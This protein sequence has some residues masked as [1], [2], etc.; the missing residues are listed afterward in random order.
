[1]PIETGE[2]LIEILIALA[3]ISLT[4]VALL[5]GLVT[6]ITSSAEHRS[7]ATVDA[8]LKS[9]AET[10]KYQI[11]E[12][13]NPLF[14]CGATVNPAPNGYLMLSTPNPSSGPVGTAVTIFGTGFTANSSAFAVTFPTAG[15]ISATNVSGSSTSHGNAT[16]SFT[17]PPTLATGSYPITVTSGSGANAISTTTPTAFQVMAGTASGSTSPLAGFTLGISSILNWDTSASPA[18]FDTKPGCLSDYGLQMLTLSATAPNNVGDT[19]SFVVSGAPSAQAPTITS[20]PTTTFTVGSAGAFTFTATGYPASVFSETGALPSGVSLD[21]AGLLYGTPA[22]FS[23]GDYPITVTASNG[24]SPNATQSFTLVVGQAP[25]IT[26]APNTAFTMGTAGSFAVAATGFPAPTF[27]ETGALPSGVS[28]SASGV[29]SGTPAPGTLGTYGT[30]NPP[31]T[32]TA[33]NG[34]A[35]NATQSFTLVVGQIPAINSAASTTFTVGSAGSFTVTTSVGYPAPTFSESGALPSGVTFS[36]AGVLSGTPAAG[37]GG[38]YSI[39]ITAANLVGTDTQSFTLT[40]RQ[41]S[42]ITSASSTTFSVGSGG[43]FTVTTTG[44]PAPTITE[45]GSLPSG[46]SFTGGTGTAKLSGTPAVGTGGTYTITL[47]ATNTVSTANQTFTLTVNQAPAITSAASTTFTVGSSGSF[48]VTATGHPSPTFTETGAL[49]SGVTL[50]GAGLLSGAPAAGTGGTYSIT[51]TASNGVGQNATQ[52]FTLTV[53]QAPAITSA[54]STTFTVNKAGSFTVAATGYPAPT[55]SETGALP[56]GVTFSAAGVL[57]GTATGTGTYN[58]TITASNGVSPNATQSFTLIVGQIPAITSA[59]STTFTV[60][61]S[62]SF[63]VTATGYP[64][65]TFTETG[66]LPAGVS[67]SAAGVLSGTPA[68]F[69]NGTYN[70]TI[71]ATNAV[72]TATQQFTLTVQRVATAFTTTVNGSSTSASIS[73]GSTAT[74]AESGLPAGATGTVTFASGSTT[75]CTITLP[76]TSCTT[77]PTLPIGSYSGFSGVFTDTDGIYANSTSTNALSLNVSVAATVFSTTVNGSSTSATITH[78]S[79]ATLAESGLPAG[80]TG[81]V[82]FASGSTTLCT[83]TLPAT[84][85]TTSPTLPAGTYSSFKGAFNDTDGHYANSSSTNA[86]TLTVNVPHITFVQQNTLN[87]ATSG[88]N[89]SSVGLTLSSVTAGDALVLVIADQSS[90]GAIVSSVSGGG[91]TWSKAASTGST[92]NG[93]AE[94][95][96]G[97]NS[98]GTSGSTTITVNLS[99]TTNVQIADVSEYSGVATSAALDKTTTNNASGTASN[100][101]VSAGS[102]TPVQTGELVISDAYL[103]NG[104]S[105]QPVPSNGFTSL[106]QSAG[107]SGNYKGYG[108]YLIDG[109]A[110]TISTTWTGPGSGS[111]VWS[112]AVASFEP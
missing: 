112:S 97:L 27:S 59:A 67:L 99:Q 111:Y 62:G 46:V 51:I 90:N 66:A 108:A 47:T 29:F 69:S 56:A 7:L 1:V 79:T 22:A 9:F 65:P 72:G 13:P 75:L 41:A 44:F 88:R 6:A 32:I 21:G 83:I 52:S 16:V 96:Y 60:G 39:T 5:G 100:P 37:T 91:V 40:V 86:L 70:I 110:S 42:A 78:G 94:I 63:A 57:S 105:T 48:T 2:T 43:N 71:T 4:V 53:D 73:Y 81:T 19:L 25:V 87:V 14:A 104:T 103:S 106:T 33:T 85:C 3:V 49:P 101:A 82:T 64:A 58:I 20:A 54:A 93:D 61:S 80:A 12:Q 76:A 89:V 98:S 26:S 74:L 10:A 30:P 17:I 38:T 55:F 77:S 92:A 36:G 45:S 84:S 95:W 68:A 50:N 23:G 28:F 35:P 11:E 24:V 34:F 107:L 102:I 31:I 109:S 18:Q 8:L 15:G